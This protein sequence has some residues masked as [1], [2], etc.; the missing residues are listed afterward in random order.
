MAKLV[1]T[2]LDTENGHDALDLS[3]TP[4][5]VGGPMQ[6]YAFTRR[7]LAG[8]RRDGIDML[9]VDNG[10]LKLAVLPQRGMG[11]WKGWLGE[12][13]IGWKSPA[14]G[15][16][17]PRF[18]P[19]YEPSGLGWLDG[20]DELLCRC[21]LESNGAPEFDDRGL[22]RYPLHGKIANLPT[23]KLEL[24][25]DGDSGE[26][27]LTGIVDEARFHFQK[28]RLT[29]TLTT[30][31]GDA[32]FSIRDEVTN[33]SA[34]RG[35]FQMLYHINFGP[36]LLEAG[37]RVVAPVKTLV[38]RNTRA[39][40]VVAH[41]DCC[42]EPQPGFVEQVYFLE[43]FSDPQG[44]TQALL[45]NAGGTLGVAMHF[46]TRQLPC[47]TLWKNTAAIVD[48][49][50]IGLEPGTNFPNPRTYEGA[51]QRMVALEPGESRAFD[52]RLEFLI[53]ETQIEKAETAIAALRRNGGA[54]RL[55]E[56]PQPGWC[57]DCEN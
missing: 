21:G 42:R 51:R 8:G 10:V 49:Y 43:L 56:Q 36:P 57:V 25:I 1:M 52:L 14:N 22:L 18:V 48:G 30:K 7:R 31:V 53:G 47:F 5:D 33:L 39:A 44:A 26:I 12:T 37:A 55:H 34:S 17:H 16:V 27:S 35:E 32:G 19:I 50:V 41:W 28:L 6:G 4:N 45:R 23:H 3:V 2:L 20:F 15:P 29:S 54:A 11:I 46:D 9:E 38:P 40:K 13:E 24:A